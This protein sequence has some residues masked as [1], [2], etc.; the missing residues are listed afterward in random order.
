MTIDYVQLAAFAKSLIQE[1]GGDVIVQKLSNTP[2]DA[3]KPWKGPGVPT[4]EIS[5]TV[6]GVFVSPTSMLGLGAVDD[7]LL[8]RVN[9]FVIAA[10]PDDGSSLLDCHVLLD[11]DGVSY[12][13][14]NIQR[15]KPATVELIYFIAANR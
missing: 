8:K 10:P 13:I 4:V 3:D 14:A 6:Q 9:T 5:K 7:D 11:Q 2:A 12:Q 15:L 1:A